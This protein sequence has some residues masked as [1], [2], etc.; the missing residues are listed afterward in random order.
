MDAPRTQ[1]GGHSVDRRRTRPHGF[2]I[3]VASKQ[4]REPELTALRPAGEVVHPGADS[5]GR[6]GLRSLVRRARQALPQGRTLPDKV[7]TRRHRGLLCLLWLQAP[8]MSAYGLIEG[9]SLLHGLA[10]GSAIVFFALLGTLLRDRRARSAAVS[11]GL[12]TAC[13]L[14]VHISGGVI[15]AH[16]YFFVV[17]IL[18]TLYEDWLPF[19]LAVGYV[20][21]HHGVLGA[22]DPG[23]VYNHSDAEAN[24]WKW[25]LV[26]GGFVLAAGAAGVLSWR[27]N[28]DARN[29]AVTAY[30]SARQ[31]EERFEQGFEN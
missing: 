24:P 3:S 18:L 21:L 13:A 4:L 23:S 25:A 12:L 10:E 8:A 31:S 1:D 9:F 30:R 26:H 17:I 11:L 29:S 5:P 16:F 2:F 20:V 28:E 14:A 19:G 27:L 7:W 22:V 15:E 6:L